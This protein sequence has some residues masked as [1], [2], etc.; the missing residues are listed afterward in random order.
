MT[1]CTV[2]EP[3]E[4]AASEWLVAPLRGRS[5]RKI[6]SSHVL[7]PTSLALVVVLRRPFASNV[8]LQLA[9]KSFLFFLFFFDR[10]VVGQRSTA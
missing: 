4:P 7:S 5:I 10:I 9:S 3:R 1:H 8:S 6:R 2:D